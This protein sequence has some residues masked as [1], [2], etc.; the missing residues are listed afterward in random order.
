MTVGANCIDGSRSGLQC[1]WPQRVLEHLLLLFPNASITLHNKAQGGRHYAAWIES[2]ELDGL[3]TEADVLLID[4]QV[5]SQVGF[6]G[7]WQWHRAM[8]LHPY[9]PAPDET[10]Q[11]KCPV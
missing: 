7:V 2:G 8:Y 5:N 10:D 1:A 3:V 11:G 6:W 9:C 4:L